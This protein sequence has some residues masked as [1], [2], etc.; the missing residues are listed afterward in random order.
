MTDNRYRFET[1]PD[2]F[3]A[4][5]SR[6]ESVIRRLLAQ[7]DILDAVY[8]TAL[9]LEGPVIELG[10]GNGRTFDHLRKRLPGRRII[11]FDRVL[12][13]YRDSIPPEGDL[14]LGEI[15]ETAARFAGIGAALVHADVGTGY[16]E[17]DAR[18]LSWLPGLVASLLRPSGLAVSGLQLD[19]PDIEPLPVPP[20]VPEGRYFLY[21]RR[22]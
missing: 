11:A 19:H 8:P 3:P 4:A 22:G 6:L 9:A 17:K 13:A 5:D 1:C 15:S 14:V 21:R 18:T 10:L 16:E 2:G 20:S 7:R 12:A